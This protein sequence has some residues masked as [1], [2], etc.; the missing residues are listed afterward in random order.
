[1]C[2]L[3]GIFT[4]CT[5][6]FLILHGP[7]LKITEPCQKL[8]SFMCSCMSNAQNTDSTKGSRTANLHTSDRTEK[9][10]A[11]VSPWPSATYAQ[12]NKS[13][14]FECSTSFDSS[15]YGGW[16][17]KK[18]ESPN[19]EGAYRPSPYPTPMKLPDEMQTPGTVYP[20]NF[21]DLPN[22][23]PRVQSQFLYPI[24]NIGENVSRSKILEEEDF[25]PNQDSRKLGESVEQP[26][27]AT[28]TSEK[29]LKKISYENESK[30]EE[31]LSS[32]LKPASVILEERNKRMEIAYS[33]MRKTP[34]D[35]PIIGMVAAHWSE[36]EDSHVPAP[37]WW[38]G[39]GIPNSTNKYKEV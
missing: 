15:E 6:V 21:E 31:S 24:D 5:H 9:N 3:Y 32:W 25:N 18:T 7:F 29:G 13:V 2:M 8:I 19:N 20:A 17:I 23:K 22:G 36:D 16:H 28:S 37:K 27:N 10:T 11:S 4:E 14:R 39:N 26:Q 34:A 30:V 35:R 12:R 33:Q 38:D 1:M